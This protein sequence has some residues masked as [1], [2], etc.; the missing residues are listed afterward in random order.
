MQWNGDG[1]GD[2]DRDGTGQASNCNGGD[3][4][5]PHLAPMAFHMDLLYFVYEYLKPSVH[6]QLHLCPT[7]D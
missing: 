2:G 6:T 7:L 5:V 3:W 4:F 1:D